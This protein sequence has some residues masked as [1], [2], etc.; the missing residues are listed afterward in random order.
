[1]LCEKKIP[2]SF[3]KNYFKKKKVK[4]EFDIKTRHNIA[5]CGWGSF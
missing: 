2:L 4:I 5:T 3:S 1:M